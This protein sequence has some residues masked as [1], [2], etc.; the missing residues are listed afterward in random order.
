MECVLGGIPIMIMVVFI[1]FIVWAINP[2]H[3]E[4]IDKLRHW[5][6]NG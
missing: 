2:R 5:F 4:R 6:F 3:P 1:G